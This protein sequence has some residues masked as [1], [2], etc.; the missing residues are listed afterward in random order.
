MKIFQELHSPIRSIAIVTHDLT[1]AATAKRR[2]T[3]KDGRIVADEQ[4][5]ELTTSETYG[6]TL[7]APR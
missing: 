7:G 1:V 3:M 2:I 4:L 6:G 5:G